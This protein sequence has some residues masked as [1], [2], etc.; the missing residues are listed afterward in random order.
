VLKV[1][2]PPCVDVPLAASAEVTVAE[3]ILILADVITG[4][5]I[6]SSEVKYPV[7]AILESSF[8]YL[9]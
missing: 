8:L 7:M 2:S 4:A 9:A 5:P 3:P 6:D 1:A